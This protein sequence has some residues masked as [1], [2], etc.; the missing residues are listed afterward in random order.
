M[1]NT[2]PVAVLNTTILTNDG[3]NNNFRRSKRNI[4]IYLQWDTKAQVKY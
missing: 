2:L 1:K 4:K 3:E